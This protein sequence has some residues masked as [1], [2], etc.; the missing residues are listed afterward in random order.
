MPIS[1]RDLFRKLAAGTAA[2]GIVNLPLSRVVRAFPSLRMEAA[3]PM[4]VLLNRDENAYGPSDKVLEVLHDAVA[5]GNRYPRTECE[6]LVSKIAATHAVQPEQVVLG[7]GLSALFRSVATIFLGPGKKLIQASPT[8]PTLGAFAQQVGADITN[9]QINKR[10]QHDLPAMLAVPGR[11]ASLVYICNPNGAIG[12][13]TPRKDIEAFL[14]TLPVETTVLIDET[15]HHFV[16][17]NGEYASFLDQPVRDPRVIVARSF[18][19]AYGLA[20]MRVGYLIGVPSVARRFEGERL[21]ADV[22]IVS[23][24][25]AAAALDDAEYLQLAIKR[26]SDDRQEFLNRVNGYMLRALDSHTNF[27]MLKPGRPVEEVVEH[28]KGQNVLIGPMNPVMPN[29]V[30]VSLGTPTEM[31]AFWAAWNLMPATGKMEM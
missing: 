23:A 21:H 15:Y 4:Q 8:S 20:G 10:Y 16:N 11:P 6:S 7:P 17:P 9:I 5:S 2:A 1:R 19:K 18:S 27:I 14:R 31:D 12:T 30:R 28:L 24:R 3:T 29:Y 22:T 13:L 25:A 26:N